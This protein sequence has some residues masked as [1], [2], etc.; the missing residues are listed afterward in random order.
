MNDN[1]YDPYNNYQISQKTNAIIQHYKIKYLLY[2]VVN[3]IGKSLKNKNTNVLLYNDKEKIDVLIFTDNITFIIRKIL[4]ILDEIKDVISKKVG[5][6]AKIQFIKKGLK[7][8]KDVITLCCHEECFLEGY[9]LFLY[10]N[11]DILLY[12]KNI[13]YFIDV[14]PIVNNYKDNVKL[15]NVK[16]IYLFMNMYYSYIYFTTNQTFKQNIKRYKS[17]NK[18][19]MSFMLLLNLHKRVFYCKGKLINFNTK[20]IN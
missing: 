8:K 15:L 14:E 4:P 3:L 19:R 10:C 18:L 7:V 2:T 16:G 9:E 12:I 5:N 17:E 13:E 1:F 6:K 11:K 20:I